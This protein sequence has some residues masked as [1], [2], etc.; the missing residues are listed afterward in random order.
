MRLP[1]TS[2]AKW[3]ARYLPSSGGF[4]QGSALN[5]IVPLWPGHSAVIGWG[6][7]AVHA[8]RFCADKVRLVSGGDDACVRLWDMASQVSEDLKL[9]LQH[10]L[11]LCM[12]RAG[13][14]FSASGPGSA[15][16]HA[17][18]APQLPS[19]CAGVVQEAV[20]TFTGHSDYV[21]SLANSRSSPDLWCVRHSPRPCIAHNT[22]TS[23]PASR[24]PWQP[25]G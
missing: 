9:T 21:R 12:L 15:A 19:R 13:E 2:S 7:R 25:P 23:P 17:A 22:G 8:T 10:P 1:P 20:S 14:S 6:C 5:R 16:V 24:W 3:L 4:L 11:G 18:P